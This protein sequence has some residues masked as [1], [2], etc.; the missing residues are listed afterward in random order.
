MLPR[1][2]FIFVY[3]ALS[4]GYIQDYRSKPF[5]NSQYARLTFHFRGVEPY[6]CYLI[7]TDQ[8][9]RNKEKG[10]ANILSPLARDLIN[11]NTGLWDLDV[12]FA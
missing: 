7:H 8:R 2:P 1:S 6:Y 11:T 5:L 4:L 3:F 9:K 10:A 12:A